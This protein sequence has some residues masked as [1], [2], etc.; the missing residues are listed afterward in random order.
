MCDFTITGPDD[1]EIGVT[2]TAFYPG[3]PGSLMEPPEDPEC[4]YE[5]TDLETGEGVVP[6]DRDLDEAEIHA[7]C[8]DHVADFRIS[9]A[10]AKAEAEYDDRRMGI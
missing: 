2:V 9:Q 1:E 8:L 4:E 10:E 7:A 5:L 3:H 6:E